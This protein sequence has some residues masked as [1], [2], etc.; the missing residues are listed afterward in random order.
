MVKRRKLFIINFKTYKQATGSRALKLAKICEK[1][2]NKATI[3]IAVQATDISL[4]SKL[5]IS[6]LAQNTDFFEQGRNTGK[7]LPEAIK[8][9]GAIGTIINHSENPLKIKE[10]KRTVERCKIVP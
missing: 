3:M 4:V 10:I 9:A 7:V 2:K 5:K 8:Q 6:V 1:F